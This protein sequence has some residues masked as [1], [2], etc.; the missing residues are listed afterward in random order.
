MTSLLETAIV[1]E[2]LF[3]HADLHSL[4]ESDGGL[5]VCLATFLG[6]C[7]DHV[8][9]HVSKTSH[10][11]FMLFKKVKKVLYHLAINTLL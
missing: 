8:N 7:E 11:V 10:Q 4:Q 2:K 9:L 5:Y 1:L 6:F 3:S